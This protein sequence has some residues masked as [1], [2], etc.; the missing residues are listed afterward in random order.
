M[1]QKVAV[2]AVI[3]YVGG[4]YCPQQLLLK[5]QLTQRIGADVL[6]ALQIVDNR[7]VQ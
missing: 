4:S 7:V 5:L 2:T 3:L 1:C 6:H